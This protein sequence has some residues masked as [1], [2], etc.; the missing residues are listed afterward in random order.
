MKLRIDERNKRI[1]EFI[2]AEKED[3]IL[4]IG[5]GVFP[6]IEFWLYHKLEC[7][8]IISGDI[9]KKNIEE[10]KRILKEVKFVYLDGERKLGFEDE[11][12]DKVIMTEVLE[13]LKSEKGVLKE[14]N[15]I[16]KKNGKLILS[17]PKRRWFNIFNPITF[18]QHKREYSERSLER[19]LK[20]TGF[21]V[22]KIF[23]GGNFLEL[24]SL[25]IHLVLKHF[26]G[27][28]HIDSFFPRK[29]DKTYKKNTKIKGTD[30]IVQAV[31]TSRRKKDE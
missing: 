31:K 29:I 12:F 1:I 15:R 30:I 27:V 5:T 24:V 9:D 23:V 2:E 20:E 7:K 6:K 8:N 28:L 16:L 17:V 10:G 21:E 25:W 18:I 3:K 4:I 13:H 19:V 26:F 14:V 22:N 11:K